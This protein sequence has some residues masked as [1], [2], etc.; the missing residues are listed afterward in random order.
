MPRRKKHYKEGDW[1]ALPLESGGYALGLIARMKGPALLGYFFGPRY[2]ELPTLNDAARQHPTDAIARLIFGDLDLLNREW[3][4]LGH[5]PDWNRERWPMPDFVS[6]DAVSDR[7]YTRTY[8]ENDFLVF[9]S[10]RRAT[11]EEVATLPKDG[12]CGSGA[13]VI[14]VSHLIR[15]AEQLKPATG[16]LNR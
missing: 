12:L 9:R 15:Q 6:K 4:A 16:D 1:F 5:L 7:F 3:P 8:D 13:V 2:P 10:E 11:P 14:K